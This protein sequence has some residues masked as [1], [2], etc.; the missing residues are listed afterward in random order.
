EKNSLRQLVTHGGMVSNLT[1]TGDTR[2]SNITT[3]G[4]ATISPTAAAGLPPP[5]HHIATSL[6]S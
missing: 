6:A 2:W 5:L 1:T 4:Y 3:K